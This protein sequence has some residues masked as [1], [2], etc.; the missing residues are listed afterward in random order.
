MMGGEAFSLR[1]MLTTRVEWQRDSVQFHRVSPIA[2]QATTMVVMIT[3]RSVM[4]GCNDVMIRRELGY[5][6]P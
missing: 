3:P 1:S 5:A 2:L 4:G 6:P